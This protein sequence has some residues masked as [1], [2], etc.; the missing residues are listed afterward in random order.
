MRAPTFLVEAPTVSDRAWRGRSNNFTLMRL[1]L[2]LAVVVS[3]AFSVTTGEVADE[4][5]ARSHR[6]HPR[7]ARGERLLRHLRLSR[8]DELRP[9]RLAR[10]R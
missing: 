10:L 9:A 2:A 3:H 8:H 4:P 1:A 7:R 6:L 5:L